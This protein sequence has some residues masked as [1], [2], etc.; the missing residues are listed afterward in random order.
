VFK[1]RGIAFVVVLAVAFAGQ[2]SGASA[3]GSTFPYHRLGA[4]QCVDGGVIR[5]YP[6]AAMAPTEPTDFRSPEQVYWSPDLYRKGRRGWRR[7]REGPIFFAFTSS[8][9]FYQG[10]FQQAW[11]DEDIPG[12]QVL[13][14]PFTDLRAGRYRVKHFMWWDWGLDR[15]HAQRQG[16]CSFY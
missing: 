10:Q 7:V 12:S 6:P 2:P 15:W 11:H 5:V 3:H 8:Y 9:G 4:M 13:F 14:H 1:L 16:T